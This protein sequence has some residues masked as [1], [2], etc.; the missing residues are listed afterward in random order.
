MDANQPAPT[1][2]ERSLVCGRGDKFVAQYL[3]SGSGQTGFGIKP[4]IVGQYTAKKALWCGPWLHIV[5]RVTAC[6][7]STDVMKKI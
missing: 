5:V 6:V 4:Q 1:L 3:L 7:M 2:R